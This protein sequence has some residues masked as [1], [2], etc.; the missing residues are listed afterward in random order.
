M[1]VSTN[2]LNRD[3]LE[4]KFQDNCTGKLLNISPI[5][6]VSKYSVEQSLLNRNFMSEIV[7]IV[8]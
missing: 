1:D 3:F 4:S 5:I 8:E 6:L 2:I 7:T